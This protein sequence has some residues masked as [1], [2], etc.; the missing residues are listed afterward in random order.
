MAEHVDMLITA[1]QINKRLDELA[2]QIK[3]DYADRPV[4]LICALKGAVIFMTDLAR[5]LDNNVEMDFL[6]VSSYGSGTE[7]TGKVKL[8]M[9]ISID[10]T[11]KH[12][13]LIEDIMDTGHTL[14]FLR[15]YFENEVKPATF[16]IC[17]LL[18]KPERRVDKR[19]RY[20][21]LGFEIPD[22][23][24][25]GYGLDYDQRYRNLPYIGVL[26]FTD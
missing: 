6:R 12:I 16:R 2:A 17:T 9:S 20:D 26:R 14:V 4:T 22:K 13:L 8:D 21:Y 25:V 24:V 11:D 1:E 23:F 18:D 5:R 7:S 3:A 10:A 15:N 19:A